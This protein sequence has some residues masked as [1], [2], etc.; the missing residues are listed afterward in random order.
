MRVPRAAIS[1]AIAICFYVVV[2]ALA[3]GDAAD[4]LGPRTLA[5]VRAS[6]KLSRSASGSRD[7]RYL[8]AVAARDAIRAGVEAAQPTV[9]VELLALAR[10]PG[11]TLSAGAGRL[12]VTNA[13]RSVSRLEG[14]QYYSSSHGE[15]RLLYKASYRIASPAERKRLSDPLVAAPPP[16]EEIWV[17]QDDTTFGGNVYAVSYDNDPGSVTMRVANQTTLRYLLFPLVPPD[18]MVLYFLIVPDGEELL[19]YAVAAVRLSGPWA[20]A[21]ALEQSFSYR[22]EAMYRWFAAMVSVP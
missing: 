8:P 13:L 6:G 4:F 3:A 9:V 12:A 11:K 21:G 19:F 10:L 17:Y 18:G 14:L 7:L 5:A 15:M 2:C 22:V 20:R 16:H 1:A